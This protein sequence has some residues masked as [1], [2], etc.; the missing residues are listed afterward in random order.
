MRSPSVR[1]DLRG[2]FA[3]ANVSLRIL[4]HSR[5][6]DTRQRS[7]DFFLSLIHLGHDP[8]DGAAMPGDDQR[9]ASLHVIGQLRQT[10]FGFGGLD[11]THS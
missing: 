6:R 10:G 1:F 9:F 5:Q 11:F 4:P 3:L 7:V 2:R 8:G